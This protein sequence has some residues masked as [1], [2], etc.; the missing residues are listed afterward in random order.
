M[1]R[2]SGLAG[3]VQEQIGRSARDAALS[4]LFATV[5]LRPIDPNRPLAELKR[6]ARRDVDWLA[7]DVRKQIGELNSHTASVAENATAA[8]REILRT[9]RVRSKDLSRSTCDSTLPATE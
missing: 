9:W 3:L 6:I 2:D 4:I 5:K 8:L 7:D 1:N